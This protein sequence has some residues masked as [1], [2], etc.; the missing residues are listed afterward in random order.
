MVRRWLSATMLG[1]KRVWQGVKDRDED[2]DDGD[3]S[4]DEDD[5]ENYDDCSD[6]DYCNSGCWPRH[7]KH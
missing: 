6:D 7:T 2:D 5:I 1:P 3:Y 4:N